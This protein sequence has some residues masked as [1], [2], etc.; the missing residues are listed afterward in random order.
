MPKK[1]SRAVLFG[2]LAVLSVG[3]AFA[4]GPPSSGGCTALSVTATSVSTP[5]G[6]STGPRFRVPIMGIPKPGSGSIIGT[7]T[8]TY[9][10]SSA[11][12]LYLP[13]GNIWS[14]IEHNAFAVQVPQG[15]R[16]LRVQATGAGGGGSD[17]AAGGAGQIVI[18]TILVP[19]GAAQITVL[20]GDGGAYGGGDAGVSGGGASGIASLGRP[21]LIA[22][23]GGG[24]GSGSGTTGGV[25]CVGGVGGDAGYPAGHPGGYAAR[26]G[27]GGSQTT[28]G[29]GGGGSVSPGAT[30]EGTIP[31]N[32]GFAGD[33]TWY[34]SPDPADPNYY[35]EGGGGGAGYFG[36]GGGAFGDATHQGG[37]GGGGS[38]Y[39]E[40]SAFDAHF[41]LTSNNGALYGNGGNG[42]V[43]ITWIR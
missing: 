4:G 19:R 36:G 6:A 28:P 17:C 23:G 25:G 5:V 38:S 20:V 3:P 2:L 14:G 35:G 8:C 24:A 26:A 29:A 7:Q 16:Y 10:F 41:S 37:G 18:A 42:F 43:T 34:Y 33:S 15:A 12:P 11:T 9:D 39:A 22:A 13:S 31:G 27:G 21:L 32:P 40:S 30:A 1:T